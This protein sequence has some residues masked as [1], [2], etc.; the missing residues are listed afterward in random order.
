MTACSSGILTDAG[1]CGG[2]ASAPYACIR[3]RVGESDG[4]GVS[5]GRGG[6]G[7]DS[8]RCLKELKA[9]DM[10]PSPV[11]LRYESPTTESPISLAAA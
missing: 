5:E 9:S 3:S 2:V 10:L 1:E 7:G 4:R 11:W 6:V 8:S